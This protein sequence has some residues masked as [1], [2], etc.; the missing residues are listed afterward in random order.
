MKERRI[1]TEKFDAKLC[2]DKGK[3]EER[4][5]KKQEQRKREKIEESLHHDGQVAGD[6]RV[7]RL[8]MSKQKLLWELE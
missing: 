8:R 3:M 1:Q 5:K 2:K 6:E 4:R 7:K